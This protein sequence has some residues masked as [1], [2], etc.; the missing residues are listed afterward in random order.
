MKL[1]T[2][3]CLYVCFWEPLK[4]S[5][6]QKS[7]YEPYYKIDPQTFLTYFIIEKALKFIL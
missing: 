4:N 7:F 5:Y 3:F 6:R 2:V 1:L